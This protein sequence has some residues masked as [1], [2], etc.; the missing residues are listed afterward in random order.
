MAGVDL[1]GGRRGFGLKC[2]M[3]LSNR[4]GILQ[5]EN[6]DLLALKKFS[7]APIPKKNP[8]SA[9]VLSLYFHSPFFALFTSKQN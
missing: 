7:G 5:R 9:L 3:R 6:C 2:D 1:G 8:G 4:T